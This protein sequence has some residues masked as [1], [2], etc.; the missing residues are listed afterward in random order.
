MNLLKN[1]DLLRNLLY[2]GDQLNTLAG[3]VTQIDFKIEHLDD[4]FSIV[5]NAPSVEAEQLKVIS[6]QNS[7][8]IIATVI[9]PSV[10]A[11][12]MIPLFYRKVELP[13][14]A[15]TDDVDAVH[16]DHRLEIF[17]PIGKNS[18]NNKKEVNI[19]QI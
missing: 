6:D 2:Q 3:G 15:N 17:V 4:G 5:V 14:F 9:H 7:L 10:N 16:H 12:V 13:I 8:Q 11:G 19:K 18:E 1:K